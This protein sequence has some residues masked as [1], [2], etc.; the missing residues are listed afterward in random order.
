MIEKNSHDRIDGTDT[1]S[2]FSKL[3]IYN[4]QAP[5]EDDPVYTFLQQR[6]EKSQPLISQLE[7][8]KMDPFVYAVL[9][10]G[11]GKRDLSISLVDELLSTKYI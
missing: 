9:L 5:I 7:Q 1:N 4:P 6:S 2:V 11:A 3:K 8:G 10:C